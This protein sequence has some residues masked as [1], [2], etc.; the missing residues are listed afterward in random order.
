MK[1]YLIDGVSGA[2]KTTVCDELNKRGYKAIEAD[3]VLADWI[4]P[5]TGLPT[6]DHSSY[7]WHWDKKKFDSLV[8]DT[9]E[10]NLFICGGAMNKPDF[11]HHFSKIFTL[12]L[13]DETLKERLRNRTNNDYGKKPEELAFQLKENQL[14]EQYSKERGAILI[15]ATQP[16]KTIVEEI[17]K[18]SE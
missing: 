15:D 16:I 1:I 13:D 9:R 12:H 18:N 17:I 14:T 10:G 7:N 3:E 5:L 2:G 11:L 8:Q 4:D 6:E